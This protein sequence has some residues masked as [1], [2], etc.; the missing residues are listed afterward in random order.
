MLK[1]SLQFN[2]FS[3]LDTLFFV[4]PIKLIY[5]FPFSLDKIS[6]SLKC[7][8]FSL[9]GDIAFQNASLPANLLEK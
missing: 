6:I 8:V 3:K 1:F 4:L 5:G 7:N 2:D 9:L